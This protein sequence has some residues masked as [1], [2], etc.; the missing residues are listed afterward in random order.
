MS[1]LQEKFFKNSSVVTIADDRPPKNSAGGET[2]SLNLIHR[3]DGSLGFI[4][5]LALPL[6]ALQEMSASKLIDVAMQKLDR[7]DLDS[8]KQIVRLTNSASLVSRPY[9]IHRA[10]LSFE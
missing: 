7:A 10:T 2:P 3:P 1:E 8:L 5:Y 4:L 6:P 9:Y